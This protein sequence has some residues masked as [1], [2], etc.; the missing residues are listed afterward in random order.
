MQ[1]KDR[2]SSPVM[3]TAT[4]Q[5]YL[6][7]ISHHP[8]AVKI[9]KE[10]QSKFIFTEESLQTLP[11]GADRAKAA[12]K[13]LDGLLRSNGKEKIPQDA[14]ITCKKGC[15]FCCNI[16]VMVSE[17][18]GA[19]LY[20]EA[21]K[22]GVI[23]VER[24]TEQAA[25]GV[26]DYPKNYSSGKSRCVFLGEDG[27]CRIYEDRPLACR[28]YMVVSP[29]ENCNPATPITV[30]VLASLDVAVFESAA[31]NLSDD[32]KPRTLPGE[33]LSNLMKE[34]NK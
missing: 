21:K 30:S 19:L 15:S 25:W 13:M 24:L 12:Q 33:I 4:M 34:E 6:E 17:D 26:S 22:L 27:A 16:Q 11:P 31:L 2:F 10:L 14:Q 28:S 18:E 29:A 32:N 8:N 5:G 23:D 1:K 7:K 3:V 20:G 9:V